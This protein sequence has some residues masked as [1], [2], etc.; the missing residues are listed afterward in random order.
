VR[1]HL[2][3]VEPGVD[4][5]AHLVPGLEHLA[6]VDPLEREHVED[7]RVEV[8]LDRR[9]RDAEDRDPAAVRHVRDTGAQRLCAAG[10]LEHH[11]EALGHA[12]LALDVAEVSLAGIDR[13]RR[14]H[15]PRELEARR[16][17][18][19]RDDVT[20]TG[21]PDDRDRHAA[22]RARARDEHVLA[23]DGERERRV[24]GVA[25]RVEDRRDVLRDAR[26]VVPDVGHR[27]DDVLR[28]RARPLD[29]EPDRVRAEL[30]TARHAVPTAPADDVAL[31]P[32]DIAR[33]E[34]AHVRADLRD[35]ADELV[36][37]H[38]RHRDRPLRPA[39][40]AMDVD[41]GAAHPGLAHADLDVVD[42]DLRLGHVLQPEPR[43]GPALHERLHRGGILDVTHAT[44]AAQSPY[45]L[46]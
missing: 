11:V 23:E 39:V 46:V 8:E 33:P 20:G 38:E 31:A 15:P 27:E 34:V 28:E 21:V 37:D 26:P 4:E 42:P 36:A 25:E 24:D 2:R 40:P 12:E 43:L 45:R 41:V 19:G 3:D 29:A 7:H 18:V 35:L 16:V 5:D 14:A 6:A 1:D 44:S 30:A 9:G 13:E 17:E 10:H 32:D 22:D